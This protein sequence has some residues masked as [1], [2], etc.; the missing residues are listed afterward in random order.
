MWEHNA[1]VF[2]HTVK[3]WSNG[4]I[5]FVTN[6]TNTEPYKIDWVMLTISI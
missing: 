3:R 2:N 4:I 1:T 6:N 5:Y